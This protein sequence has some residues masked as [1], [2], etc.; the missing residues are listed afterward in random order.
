MS[1]YNTLVKNQSKSLNHEGAES[2]SMS[3]ELELYTAVVTA[4]LSNKFYESANERIERIAELVRNCEPRF[5]AQLAIYARQK[6]N[7]RSIPLLLVVELA[8]IH[9]GDDLV[10]RTVDA[11][12]MRADE[13]MELLHCYQW[14]NER[15]VPDT[16]GCAPKKQL[17]KLS[18]QI[19]LGLQ[20]AFNKFDEYQFAKYDRN[21]FNVKLRDALFTI[22]PK[23]KDEAQQALFDKITNKCLETPYTWETEL[24][25][26]GQM[27]FESDEAK[28]L[29]FKKKWEELISSN[30]MGY[31]ALLRNLRNI[32]NSNVDGNVLGKALN[33]IADENAVANAK[34]FPFRYLSAYK[35][36]KSANEP[37][38][39]EIYAALEKAV[40]GSVNMIPDIDSN[41]RVFVASD[42][43]GSMQSNLS[44][45]SRIMYY[46]VGILL[47]MLMS[48]KCA[49]VVAGI[50]G[51]D[52]K[53][54][55]IPTDQILKNT[56]QIRN[57]IGEVGYGTAGHKP[58]EWLINNKV[59][60]HKVMF[61]TDMQFWGHS[62]YCTHF[63]ELWNK[64]KSIAPNAKL[65]IFDLAGY[66][67]AP[68]NIPQKDVYC[69]AGWNERIFEVM[70]AIDHGS[71]IVEEI[72]KIEI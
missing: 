18:H 54:I 48:S 66:G 60:M 32:V 52:W 45:R 46:E 12:V 47:A 41:T 57:R 72:K 4:S 44:Y 63:T 30:K 43:S 8:K 27:H 26:I 11:V 33:Y 40:K 17:C 20:K 70:S 53:T 65:Y 16:S 37:M 28:A 14:R 38:R 61:F 64:Y 22:H 5:V 19:Q 31:M 62:N 15:A 25:A 69:I 49:N 9:S 24:S 42:F 59:V 1:G 23:A 51:D 21:S 35:E 71:D 67:H 39:S 6:M 56:D 2:F 29:E 10:S 36:L 3:A 7:L 68:L 55:D 50:F 58:L 34:Q 13:I